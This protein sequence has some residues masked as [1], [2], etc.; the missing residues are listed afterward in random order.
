M[1]RN[2]KDDCVKQEIVRFEKYSQRFRISYVLY[3]IVF[4]T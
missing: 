2:E 3:F 4:N 1:Y